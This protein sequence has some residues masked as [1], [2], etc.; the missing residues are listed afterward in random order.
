MGKSVEITKR[1]KEK[2]LR[3]CSF[4]TGQL[5]QG[6]TNT[7]LYCYGVRRNQSVS[8]LNF[9]STISKQAYALSTTYTRKRSRDMQ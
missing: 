7:V 2:R 3:K 4:V 5:F 1:L 9:H 6:A 8:S